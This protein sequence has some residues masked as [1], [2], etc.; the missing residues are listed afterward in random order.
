MVGLIMG[1][2]LGDQTMPSHLKEVQLVE[3]GG[4]RVGRGPRSSGGS[5]PNSGGPR[6]C[7]VD[8]GRVAK[9]CWWRVPD[10]GELLKFYYLG[11]ALIEMAPTTVINKD[12]KTHF[13]FYLIK[14][15]LFEPLYKFTE[16][17]FNESKRT[18]VHP[19]TRSWTNVG[20]RGG[21]TAD[22][23]GGTPLMALED[24]LSPASVAADGGIG[25]PRSPP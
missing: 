18:D 11:L 4:K 24:C 20:I 5:W 7:T 10:V 12:A 8:D 19:K 16:T 17:S 13:A 15:G 22:V 14:H 9:K 21:A 25:A 6:C 3:L 2:F 1:R 23:D